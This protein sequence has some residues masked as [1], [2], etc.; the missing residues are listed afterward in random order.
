MN[1]NNQNSN[2]LFNKVELSEKKSEIFD[3]ITNDICPPNS[4]QDAD[5]LTS[6][7]LK[8][9]KDFVN[10]LTSQIFLVSQKLQKQ[11][12]LSQNCNENENENQNQFVQQEGENS[13]PNNCLQSESQQQLTQKTASKINKLLESMD[14]EVELE[15]R[16]SFRARNCDGKSG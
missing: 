13:G 11:E 14:T 8:Y 1:N 9:G 12:N 6:Q 4:N 2:S 7:T 5:L 3:Q 16:E 10:E 15:T